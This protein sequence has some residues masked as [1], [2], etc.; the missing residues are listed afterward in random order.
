MIAYDETQ[1]TWLV[2][3]GP[4]AAASDITWAMMT[5]AGI[6]TDEVELHPTGTGGDGYTLIH[7]DTKID[8]GPAVDM[9]DGGTHGFDV[10]VY[11]RVNDGIGGD[12]YW[13]S[14]NSPR[15]YATPAEVVEF[16]AG[17]IRDDAEA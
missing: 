11:Q 6:D 13:D 3:K 14:G 8:F 4:D 9:E 10:M 7:G 15:W 5:D 16:V 1:G 12:F 2:R 17:Q